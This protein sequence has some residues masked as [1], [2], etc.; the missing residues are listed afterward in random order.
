MS[1]WRPT[2]PNG[3]NPGVWIGSGMAGIDGLDAGDVVT[4]EQMQA[5]FGVGL[6]PLAARTAAAA[7]GAGPDRARTTRR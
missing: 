6:H 1:G 2:T 3:R 7:A 5:L 4:A